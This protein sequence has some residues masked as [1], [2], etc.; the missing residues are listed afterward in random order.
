MA[1]NAVMDINLDLDEIGQ[2]LTIG[3]SLNKAGAG[4]GQI[5]TK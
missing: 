1:L 4:G 5:V 2:R 3:S